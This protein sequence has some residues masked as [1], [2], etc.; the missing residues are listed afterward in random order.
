MLWAF[1]PWGVRGAGSPA[2]FSIFSKGFEPPRRLRRHTS[3]STEGK[4]GH[5]LLP[6][7]SVG[8]KMGVFIAPCLTKNLERIYYFSLFLGKNNIL[9]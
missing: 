6:R 8:T 7:W 1:D 2:I 9:L 5:T 4:M 3:L